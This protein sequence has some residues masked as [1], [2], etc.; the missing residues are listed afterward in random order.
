MKKILA[1]A[2][3]VAM[4]L[5]VTAV[6][7]AVTFPNANDLG[8]E[9]P[10][11][12]TMKTKLKGT[13]QYVTLDQPVS[14]MA[15]V[16]NWGNYTSLEFDENNT[17]SYSTAGQSIQPGHAF[18][19]WAG[20]SL[21]HNEY[22]YSETEAPTK[23]VDTTKEAYGSYGYHEITV[24][25]QPKKYD[26]G[27]WAEIPVARYEDGYVE[28]KNVYVAA[29]TEDQ[30][31]VDAVVAKAIEAVA[32][33]YLN[34]DDQATVK[35]ELEAMDFGADYYAN[36]FYT[37]TID[38]RF[39]NGGAYDTEYAYHGATND[40]VDVKYAKD[41][42][43]VFETIETSGTEFF[44]NGTSVK[45]TVTW[46]YAKNDAKFK[47]GYDAHWFV[48][49]ISEIKEEYE[50]GSSLRGKFSMNGKCVS[51]LSV[52]ANGVKSPVK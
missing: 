39:Y 46:K 45:T 42:K 27:Y 49:Y 36:G 51:I 3:A 6:A 9:R 28:T 47:A 38:D 31:A 4:I 40:G 30:A 32:S 1:L 10:E 8:L 5:S 2:L 50:D 26:A 11:I 22:F 20:Y 12:P 16:R 48:W 23:T 43:P 15:A 18:W 21:Y 33:T 52:D 41:G 14:W 19:G 7:S 13:T 34:K 17:A 35:A 24:D 44:G 25:G 37:A 29:K